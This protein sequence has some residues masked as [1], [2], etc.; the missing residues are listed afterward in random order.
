M[1]K[2]VVVVNM[3][4]EDIAL[5]V[6]VDFSIVNSN[7]KKT[8]SLLNIDINDN[9]NF[10]LK[11]LFFCATDSELIESLTPIIITYLDLI[12]KMDQIEVGDFIDKVEINMD[13]ILGAA[14]AY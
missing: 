13:F 11:E 9:Y 12:G 10:I 2:K 6:S 14:C 5:T 1:I 3:Y 4:N 8:Q 7:E